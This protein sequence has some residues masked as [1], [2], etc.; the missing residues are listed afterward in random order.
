MTDGRR[1]SIDAAPPKDFAAHIKHAVF[2]SSLVLGGMTVGH[3]LFAPS[4][5]AQSVGVHVAMWIIGGMI[6]GFGLWWFEEERPRRR[7]AARPDP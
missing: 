7:A 4:V 2:W 6:Y 1:S 5:T 3:I